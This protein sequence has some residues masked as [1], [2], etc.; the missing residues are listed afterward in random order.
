VQVPDT[1]KHQLALSGIMLKQAPSELVATLRGTQAE[2]GESWSQGGPAL[3]R[4]LPGQSILYGY[5]VINPKIKGG[6]PG[7][8]AGSQVRVFR[9]GQLIYTGKYAHGLA[10]SELDPTRLVGGG[11]L[12]LGKQLIAGE[13]LL[14]VIVTDEQ[15]DKK[16][17]QVA[18][19]VDFEVVGP[20]QSRDRKGAVGAN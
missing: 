8:K 7:F 4:Y 11:V 12:S 17:S 19:W 16:H 1:R 20:G 18:Q 9:D 6:E 3:R 5:A 15:G 14:Q 2:P 13:Y 10:K